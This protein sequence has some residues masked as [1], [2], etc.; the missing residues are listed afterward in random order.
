MIEK[1][2][3]EITLDKIF[4][5]LHGEFTGL[6]YQPST[7]TVG[8]YATFYKSKEK[9]LTE[10]EYKEIGE[11][12][13][14]IKGLKHEEHKEIMS[15]YVHNCIED[16]EQRKK[17]FNALRHNTDFYNRFEDAC[18]N[19]GIYEDY[20]DFSRDIYIDIASEWYEKYVR[21]DMV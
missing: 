19:Y 13:I 17:L 4:R 5:E 18:K 2:K 21:K 9:R 12:L 7:N 6:F 11:S 8:D 16:K 20:M 14:F 1:M 3:N 10:K 15:S